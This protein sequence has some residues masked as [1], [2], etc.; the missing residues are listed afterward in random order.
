MQTGGSPE[1]QVTANCD[2]KIQSIGG[3]ASEVGGGG[4]NGV[5]VNSRSGAHGH[6]PASTSSLPIQRQVPREYVPIRGH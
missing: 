3:G 4:V 1:V 6:V 5:R 2:V